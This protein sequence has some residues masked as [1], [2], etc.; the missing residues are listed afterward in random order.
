MF[1]NDQSHS[2]ILEKLK[3]VSLEVGDSQEIGL[4]QTPEARA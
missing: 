2:C 3:V 1:L 4:T